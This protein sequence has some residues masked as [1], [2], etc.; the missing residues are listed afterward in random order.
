MGERR[1]LVLDTATDAVVTGLARIGPESVAAVASRVV[2][3]ERRHAETLTTLMKECLDESGW[4]GTDLDAV[5]VGCGPGPFTGLRVGMV[6]AAAYGDA[7]GIPVHGVC[8]LDAIAV[9]AARGTAASSILVVTD[10][11]RREA[12]WARYRDGRRV[13]GPGVLAPALL[14]EEMA[15]EEMA[16][17]EMAGESIDLVA[18]VP[19]TR[20]PGVGGPSEGWPSVPAAPDVAALATVAAAAVRSGAAPEPLVPLYLRRPDAVELS[21]QKKKKRSGR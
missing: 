5:V 15:G 13:G 10:A 1:V 2:A 21:D 7:L 17:E 11:R 3:D 20:W 16:G 9:A 19:L 14:L 6:T 12:Y 4:R 8:T 18:G